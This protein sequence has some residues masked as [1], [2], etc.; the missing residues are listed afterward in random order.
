MV[1]FINMSDESSYDELMS[2]LSFELNKDKIRTRA[3]DITKLGIVE[4]TR[5][6]VSL[7]LDKAISL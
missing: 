6:K 2:L 1:D 7:P 3:I 5:K 4:I